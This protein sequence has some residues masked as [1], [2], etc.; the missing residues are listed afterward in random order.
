MS[1]SPSHSP[2]NSIEVRSLTKIYRSHVKQEGLAGSLKSF[3]KR[4]YKERQA[5]KGVSFEIR[6]GELVGMLG[7]NGAGKTTT[8]K[9]L[10]G[11][12]TP[13]S[14]DAHVM[15]FVPWERSNDF[16]RQFAIVMGQRNQLW[17]DLPAADAFLLNKEI[18]RIPESDYRKRLQNLAERLNIT[19]KLHV[20]VRRLS[21][22]E[23]M[24]CEL[25]GS[26]LHA[27]RVLFLDE[28]T[29]G[30][31]VIAQK[32]VRDFIREYNRESETTIILTSH[33]MSDIEEL[34]ERV[35]VIDDGAIKFDGALRDLVAGYVDEKIITIVL[36]DAAPKHELERFGTVT[37]WQPERAQIRAPRGQIAAIA[38]SILSAH[39]VVDLTIE[40]VPI[41]E[42]I[43]KIL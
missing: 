35:I 10:S 37:E 29:I 6:Q 12:L 9:M 27:P 26:L 40:E 2:Q 18:Y 32:A 23:R 21:L 17:W 31:D 41:E 28:P 13:T 38:A 43:R 25:I 34:C 5:V 3:F 14:G 1:H 19:D 36:R 39:D 22:G 20:Q 16:K 24:K 8:L 11:L 4:E 15:G 42:V 33:Y 30:L 7:A